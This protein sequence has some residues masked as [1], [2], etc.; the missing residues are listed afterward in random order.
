MKRTVDSSRFT[1]DGKRLRIIEAKNRQT[2]T[3]NRKRSP[4][5]IRNQTLRASVLSSEAGERINGSNKSNT[6]TNLFQLLDK[7]L[8]KSRHRR[9]TVFCPQGCHDAVTKI[10]NRC[11]P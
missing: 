6:G 11:R 10:G 3:G 2:P 7:P 9:F 8:V 5:L 4:I 1:V